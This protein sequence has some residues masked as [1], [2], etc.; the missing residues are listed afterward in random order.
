MSR[1]RHPK[2]EVEAAIA[3]A[4]ANGWRVSVGGGHAWG[5]IY[6]PNK[7]DEC[8]CGTFC[9][10]SVWCTPANAENHAKQLRRVVDNCTTRKERQK[11]DQDSQQQPQPHTAASAA[12]GEDDGI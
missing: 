1:S 11:S 7:D 5:K 4:E 2:K 10:A 9:I 3:H 12:P 8:R 6:C